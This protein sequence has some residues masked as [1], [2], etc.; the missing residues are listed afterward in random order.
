[1]T[2]NGRFDEKTVFFEVLA[3]FD[4]VADLHRPSDQ[5]YG[6]EDESTFLASLADYCLLWILSR[7]HAAARQVTCERRADNGKQPN[8]IAD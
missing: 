5:C 1:M 7:F 8:L 2:G 6:I 3:F 4:R